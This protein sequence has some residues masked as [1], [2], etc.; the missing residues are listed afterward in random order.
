LAIGSTIALIS[1]SIWIYKSFLPEQPSFIGVLKP[2]AC[3][4]II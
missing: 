1:S 2:H 4:R 3:A